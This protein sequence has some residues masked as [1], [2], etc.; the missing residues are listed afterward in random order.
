MLRN[1]LTGGGADDDD[2]DDD[3]RQI[4]YALPPER[5]ISARVQLV[6]CLA[7]RPRACVIYAHARGQTL[8]FR[9]RIQLVR[10]SGRQVAGGDARATD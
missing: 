5:P 8:R 9:W 2:D 4:V 10:V 3:A 1:A 7:A 6:A